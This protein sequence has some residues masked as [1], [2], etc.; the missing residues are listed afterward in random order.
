MSSPALVNKLTAAS[1]LF[2]SVWRMKMTGRFILKHFGVM[3]YLLIKIS[4]AIWLL[5]RKQ[6]NSFL[7]TGWSVGV[8]STWHMDKSHFHAG[9]SMFTDKLLIG[10]KHKLIIVLNHV[11]PAGWSWLGKNKCQDWYGVK[12]RGIKTWSKTLQWMT[13]FYL[14]LC[15]HWSAFWWCTANKLVNILIAM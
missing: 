7:V 12:E 9:L 1:L 14:C 5:N 2:Q 8:C 4:S 15:M 6:W 10:I 11:L 3:H 13:W